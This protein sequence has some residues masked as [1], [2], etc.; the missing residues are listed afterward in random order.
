MTHLLLSLVKPHLP[1]VVVDDALLIDT[2]TPALVLHVAMRFSEC[3]TSSRG[4]TEAAAM[5]TCAPFATATFV[6]GAFHRSQC[7]YTFTPGRVL[8]AIRWTCTPLLPP[9]EGLSIRRHRGQSLR[10]HGGFC[11]EDAAVHPAACS[12]LMRS[13]IQPPERV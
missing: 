2:P 1:A 13:A 12:I 5:R 7:F 10:R 11:R 4:R 8:S 6:T 9:T 3:S